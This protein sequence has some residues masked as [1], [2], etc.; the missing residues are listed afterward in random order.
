MEMGQVLALALA[1][2]F[3]MGWLVGWLQG[4]AKEKQ[5]AQELKWAT[6]KAQAEG[7]SQ[8]SLRDLDSAQ[9]EIQEYQFVLAQAK[10]N[11]PSMF[12]AQE[13]L[14]ALLRGSAQESALPQGYRLDSEQ[15]LVRDWSVEQVQELD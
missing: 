8:V 7:R 4:S 10:L 2:G 6:V 15:G 14:S 12:Q 9:S 11:H 5:L 3:L 13:S 1:L